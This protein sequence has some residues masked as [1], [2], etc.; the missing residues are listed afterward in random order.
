MV[1]ISV[2]MWA[3]YGYPPTGV[4]ITSKS[5]RVAEGRKN[6][7]RKE[8]P[9]GLARFPPPQQILRDLRSTDSVLVGCTIIL[10]KD[11]GDFILAL[12]AE[13]VE[14]EHLHASFPPSLYDVPRSEVVVDIWL[15]NLPS[16]AGD[17]DRE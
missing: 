5:G 4:A 15:G 7:M 6:N 14:K 2:C 13:K 12:L 3:E 9:R 10:A 17:L 16:E 1:E 8:F 11:L